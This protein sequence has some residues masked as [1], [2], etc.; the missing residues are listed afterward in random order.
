MAC[1][2]PVIAF[3]VGSA[4]EVV[5]HGAS[6][7]LVDDEVEM[8]AAVQRIG[9]LD[10]ATV[11]ATVAE[12][13][14]IDVVTRAYEKAYRRVIAGAARGFPTAATVLDEAAPAVPHAR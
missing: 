3:P 12:R 7:F 8:A 13:Y 4:P 6:G 14:D 10:P 11:R 1:G 9:D 5:Q 2:T